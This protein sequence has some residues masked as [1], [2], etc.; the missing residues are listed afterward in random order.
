MKQAEFN[1]LM[2][3]YREENESTILPLAQ[4]L[5]LVAIFIGVVYL[6]IKLTI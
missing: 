3:N 5:Y 1:I 2:D 6:I 4:S